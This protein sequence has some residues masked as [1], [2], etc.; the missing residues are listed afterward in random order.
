MALRRFERVAHRLFGAAAGRAAAA[1]AHLRITLQKAHIN[2]RPEVYLASAYLTTLLASLGTLL[3]VLILLGLSA[4]GILDLS[5]RT[6]IILAPAPV[7]VAVMVYLLTLVLPDL[8]AANRARDI[9]AKLPYALNYVATMASAGATPETVFA[10][11]AQQPIYGV[12]AQEAARITRDVQYLGADILTALSRGI[13]RSPSPKLEDLLQGAI[14]TLTSGGDLKTYFVQKSE[15]FLYENRQEQ[16]RFLDGLGI[17][18]ESFVTVVVAA[19]LFLIIILT[20]MTSFGGDA[21]QTLVLGYTLVFVL[22]PVSQ[23]GFAWAI[24][25]MTPEA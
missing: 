12:V 23:A 9:D 13:E 18:A 3:P 17:L 5:P 11:L 8:R 24:K 14:T 19:P 16:K 21:T 2:L 7:V 1:N 22:I 25:V 4:A 20:V 6:L 15:Q 10:S